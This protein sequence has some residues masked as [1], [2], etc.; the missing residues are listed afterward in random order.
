[1]SIL[2]KIF[3]DANE[4]YLKKL[5]PL[6]D[7]INSLEPTLESFSNEKLKE[8][9]KEFK[10]RFRKGEILNDMLPEAFALV[11]EAAKR[12]LGQRHFDWTLD[13]TQILLLVLDIFYC[14]CQNK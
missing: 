1:M 9:T 2:N 14:I 5:Q 12:T 3:G 13:Y 7:K 10:E 8:K 4:K 11:R 6:I